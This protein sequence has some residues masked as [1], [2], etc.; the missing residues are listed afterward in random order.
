MN[1]P[2]RAAADLRLLRAAVFSAVCVAL[3]ASGHVVASGST[4]SLWSLA[5]GWAGIAGVAGLLA[6][7]ER[8]LPGIALTLLAG[9]IGLHLLFCLGQNPARTAPSVDRSASVV[10]MAERLLCNPQAA[11]LT[12]L[13]AA[14]ILRLARIDPSGALSAPHGPAGMTG[15]TGMP[16]MTGMAGHGGLTAM[17]GSMCTPP[18]LAA[19]VAAA[20]LTGWVLR[21]CE[22]ALWRAVRLPAVAARHVKRLTLLWWLSDLLA[23]VRR[24]PLVTGLLERVLALLTAH[25]GTEE[26]GTRRFRSA[27]LRTC[28]ARRGPPALAPMA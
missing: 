6:G 15:M 16:G 25:R 9:E 20:V 28:A 14:R 26:G 18:M 11:H 19:H 22:V 8:S 5:A 10:A 7:R 23:A 21:R 3:S 17:L 13:A 1:V 4:I 2:I 12:P 24:R 27:M